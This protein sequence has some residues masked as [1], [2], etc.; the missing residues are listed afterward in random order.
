MIIISSYQPRAAFCSSFLGKPGLPAAASKDKRHSS[1]LFFMANQNSPLAPTNQQQHCA[2]VSLVNQVSQQQQVTTSGVPQ[3]SFP[4][5]P[6]LINS[7]YQPGAAFFL[8]NQGFQQ[9]QT[10]TGVIP[11]PSLSWQTRFSHQQL[12]TR[13]SIL[14]QSSLLTRVLSSRKQQAAFPSLVFSWPTGL[15]TSGYQTAAA[16]CS[17]FPG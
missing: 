3:P 11:Q 4:G 14:Q 17:S 1:A 7:C 12:P 16:F 10:K 8:E 15:T 9:M 5:Q 2:T 6:G 13:S